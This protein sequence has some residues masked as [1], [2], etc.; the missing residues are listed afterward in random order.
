M[1]CAPHYIKTAFSNMNHHQYYLKQEA[2][3]KLVQFHHAGFELT[4][5]FSMGDTLDELY[6]EVRR[7]THLETQSLQ[8]KRQTLANRLYQAGQ[9][10]AVQQGMPA[11]EYEQRVLHVLDTMPAILASS[12][13]KQALEDVFNADLPDIDTTRAITLSDKQKLISVIHLL[14]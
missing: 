5:E 13:A 14:Q 1:H 3:Q 9:D 6:S 12:N 11:R 10:A 7:L 4:R 2:I 8:Q